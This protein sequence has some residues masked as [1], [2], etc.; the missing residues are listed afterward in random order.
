MKRKG[1]EFGNQLGVKVAEVGC[2]ALRREDLINLDGTL[3]LL[4]T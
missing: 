3:S 1:E 2:P 4:R